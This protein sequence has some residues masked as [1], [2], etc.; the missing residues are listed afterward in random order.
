MNVGEGGAMAILGEDAWLDEIEQAWLEPTQAKRRNVYRTILRAF[1]ANMKAHRE[2]A[3]AP[4]SDA[5]EKLREL[6]AKA[7][8]GLWKLY[9]DT[10]RVCREHKTSEWNIEG[11]D[12]GNHAMFAGKENPE[13][14]VAC[15]NY[16]RSELAAAQRK[17]V[18]P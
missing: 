5:L 8:P 15:V 10:C 18:T 9:E 14:I 17:S 12:S 3:A 6:S 13:F 11:V 16:V 1:A 7:S 2:L 4:A